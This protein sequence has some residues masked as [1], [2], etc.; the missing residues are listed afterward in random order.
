MSDRGELHADEI[1]QRNTRSGALWG[2]AIGVA[3]GILTAGIG[4]IPGL[5]LGA[6]AGA[7]V[8]SLSH[9]DIGM[10]DEQHAEMVSFL[11]KGGAALAV[12]ADDFEIED[13]LAKMVAVGGRTETYKV[14]QTTQ[15]VMAATAAAQVSASSALDEAVSEAAVEVEEVTRSVSIDMPDLDAAAASAVGTVATA[16]GLTTAQASALYATG[17]AT[18]RDLLESAATPAGRAEI[19]A[20]TDMSEEEVLAAVKKLDLMRVKG[21]GHK[22]A[23]LLLATGVDTVPELARRNAAN[24]VKAMEETNATAMI[25]TNIPSVDEVAGWVAQAKELPRMIVY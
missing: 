1:G 15:D 3:V 19:A 6:G 14:P 16:A 2:T 18:P 4:L 17:Y 11:K 5:L 23:A 13:T 12:M 10:T 9:K 7:G 25:V 20:K 8:G 22:Y 21:V 24:L